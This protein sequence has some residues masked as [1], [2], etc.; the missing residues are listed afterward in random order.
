MNMFV[1]RD[2]EGNRYV[3][4]DQII[5]LCTDGSDIKLNDAF[6]IP[7]NGGR[8]RQETSSG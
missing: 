4:F 5:D 7:P 3:L 2:E 8:H 1:Q 6:I